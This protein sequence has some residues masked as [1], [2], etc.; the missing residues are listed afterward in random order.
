VTGFRAG[1]G[2]AAAQIFQVDA[3]DS[4]SALEKLVPDWIVLWNRSE[5]GT[6]FQHPQRM[7]PRLRALNRGA[8]I[9]ALAMRYEGRLVAFAPMFQY[10]H[11]AN[12]SVRQISFIGAGGPDCVDILAE[13]EFSSEAAACVL[14][15]LAGR[16]ERWDICDFQELPENSALPQAAIPHGLTAAVLPSSHR[17][18]RLFLWHS[19]S[20]LPSPDWPDN[21]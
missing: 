19:D 10:R 18:Q 1:A 20:R 6:R 14:Q 17:H 3:L 7:L 2:Q 12:S 15:Y 8:F 4:A 16:R 13:P 21:L 5:G 9:C 11:A